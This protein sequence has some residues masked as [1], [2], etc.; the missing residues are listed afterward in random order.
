[1]R[2]VELF[3]SIRDIPYKISLSLNEEDTSCSGKCIRLKHVFERVGYEVRYRVVEF[4][5]SD[6]AI[7]RE[8]LDIPHDDNSTHVYLEVLVHE[9]WVKVDPTWDKK[10]AAVVPIAEWDGVNDTAVAVPVLAEYDLI[11]SQDVMERS[12]KNEVV[13]DLKKNGEFYKKLNEWLES[14]RLL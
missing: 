1:M 12:D 3:N 8:I 7:P 14:V 2:V 13:E 10:L 9:Q 5:W 11:K 4:R 6:M